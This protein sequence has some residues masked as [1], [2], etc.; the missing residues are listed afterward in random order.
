M[1][2]RCLLAI[3]IKTYLRCALRHIRVKVVLFSTL[4]TSQDGMSSCQRYPNTSCF[5]GASNPFSGLV[6]FDDMGAASLTVF[7]VEMCLLDLFEPRQVINIEGWSSIMFLIQDVFSFWVW[8]FFFV[9]ICCGSWLTL[10]LVLV[11]I[12]TQFKLTKQRCNATFSRKIIGFRELGA[13][14]L[15]R[16]H[17]PASWWTRVVFFTFQRFGYKKVEA[18]GNAQQVNCFLSVFCLLI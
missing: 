14:L 18:E 4:I 10:N 12:A 9:L 1:K 2:I 17:P 6:S 3:R 15:E 8:P 13:S 7:Q 16:K 5:G 11:V